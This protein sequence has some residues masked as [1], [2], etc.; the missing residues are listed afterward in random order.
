MG[1]DLSYDCR[2]TFRNRS[3]DAGVFQMSRAT[4]AALCL[5]AA[6]ELATRNT[7]LTDACVHVLAIYLDQDQPR[8]WEE[9]IMGLAKSVV[10]A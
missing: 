6:K 2:N 3:L 9:S 7:A 1:E 4:D 8:E 10:T 5:E